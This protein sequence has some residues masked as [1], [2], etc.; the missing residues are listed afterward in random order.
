MKKLNILIISR[1]IFPALSPRS[2]RTIELAKEL[3]KQGH[4]V[5]VYAVLGKT[6][7]ATF[8]KETGV[9]VNNFGKMIFG[10]SD[11]DGGFRYT[12]LDKILYHSLHRLIEFP[13][14]ELMFRVPGIIKKEKGT[15]MLITIAYPYPIH[16]GAALAKKI[17]SFNK[18]PKIW[19][20]DCG[21][22]YMGNPIENNKFPYFKYV[23]KWWCR[24]TDYITIPLEEGK[25]GY[26]Q[27]FHAKIKVI[28]Q[29]FD[30]SSV[31]LQQPYV[32]NSIPTFAYSGSIY[33]GKRDPKSFLDFLSSFEQE[34][35]FIV[36]TNAPDYYI[37]YKTL[38][39][40]K[41][42]IKS[43][44]AREQLIY[45]LSKMDFLINFKNPDNIQ[46]PSKMIDYLQTKRPTI[47]ISTNFSNSEKSIFFEFIE[48]N[49]Q[50]GV[51][52]YDLEQFN[53]K[54][55]AKKFIDLYNGN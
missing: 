4:N 2:F 29:G 13:D 17:I 21:D 41:L 22:P 11:S 43:F 20:S 3:V 33:P 1:I 15:D 9:K 34:L 38:L 18:F 10:S 55:V 39:K 27:E 54:N 24:N 53:I 5:T 30:F 46:L 48:G 26:Y 51:K 6:D 25:A 23:E 45:E 42:K 50:N 8:E 37:P 14:I 47:N 35:Q 12:L 52:E 40:D 32:R 19:I 31:K 7:Y 36:Y 49:Y 28:P 16:W 44:I